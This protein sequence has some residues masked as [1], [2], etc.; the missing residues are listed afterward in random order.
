MIYVGEHKHVHNEL[1]TLYDPYSTMDCCT[2]SS[3]SSPTPAFHVMHI[4]ES[5]VDSLEKSIVFLREQHEHMLKGLHEEIEHLRRAN[6]ALQF[7]LVMC[8]CSTSSAPSK[9]TES[10]CSRSVSDLKNEVTELRRLLEEERK[11]NALLSQ[12]VETIQS[13]RQ[14]VTEMQ[15]TL[16]PHS[17]LKS[18]KEQEYGNVRVSDSS[19]Y[20]RRRTSTP[21]RKRGSQR[22]D[23]RAVEISETDK[24]THP[25]QLHRGSTT[26]RIHSPDLN[27]E[28]S[29][30]A[31][32][33]TPRTSI[34]PPDGFWVRPSVASLQNKLLPL[35]SISPR[36][37]NAR[38]T[39]ITSV[40]LPV[41][42]NS[43]SMNQVGPNEGGNLILATDEVIQE[44][45]NRTSVIKRYVNVYDCVRVLF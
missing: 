27:P 36:D 5:K 38:S 3:N 31:I 15:K 29:S 32:L 13:G 18:T 25:R 16:T 43:A 37:S 2:N 28:S 41:I 17:T 20:E 35:N 44:N 22:K 19:L 23:H 24:L 21:N 42:G 33:L 6:K 4:E 10:T 34:N 45:T 11:K 1:R 7:R 8:C 40:K 14:T 26:S 30:S 9:P 39:R 12:Q